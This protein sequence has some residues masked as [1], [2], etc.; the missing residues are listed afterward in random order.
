MLAMKFLG[1]PQNAN[2]LLVLGPHLRE[3]VD[4]AAERAQLM[5]VL[6]PNPSSREVELSC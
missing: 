3:L 5:E 1:V 2:G 4:F 6:V